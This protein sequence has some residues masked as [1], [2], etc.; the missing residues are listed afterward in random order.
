MTYHGTPQLSRY[1]RVYYHFL[2]LFEEK[3]QGWR[4][5]MEGLENGIGVHN[6]KFTKNKIY[7]KIFSTHISCYVDYNQA[8]IC[9]T[10]NWRVGIK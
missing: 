10:L 1:N 7:K 6:V 4:A 3:L 9:R 2:I 8:I 5:D